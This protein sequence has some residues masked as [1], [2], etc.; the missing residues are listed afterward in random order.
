MDIEITKV[1]VDQLT[2]LNDILRF[3]DDKR[4]RE[5]ALDSLLELTASEEMQQVF[6]KTEICTSVKCACVQNE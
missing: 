1:Y 6:L 5:A 3:M 2:Q 4:T